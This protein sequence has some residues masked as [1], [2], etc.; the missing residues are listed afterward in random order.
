MTEQ[1]ALHKIIDALK[2]QRDEK[3]SQPFIKLANWTLD[4]DAA[5]ATA[6]AENK[7]IM[8]YFTR[9]YSP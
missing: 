4:Y 7:W 9:S 3:L 1:D 5:R 6:K 8:A 2:E